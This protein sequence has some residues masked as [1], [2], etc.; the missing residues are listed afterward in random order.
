MNQRK[1]KLAAS[2]FFSSCGLSSDLYGRDWP[3]ERPQQERQHCQKHCSSDSSVASCLPSIPLHEQVQISTVLTV[4]FTARLAVPSL[5]DSQHCA[6]AKSPC[7]ALLNPLTLRAGFVPGGLQSTRWTCLLSCDSRLAQSLASR[8]AKPL[9]LF[10][11]RRRKLSC[12]KLLVQARPEKN[13][14][15]IRKSQAAT[16]MVFNLGMSLVT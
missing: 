1:T 6:R 11:L 4:C 12:Q 14:P 8:S 13:A 10:I 9:S 16:Y 2:S 5:H 3:R 15:G 7:R